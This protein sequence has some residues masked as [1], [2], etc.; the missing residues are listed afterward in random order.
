MAH[1]SAETKDYAS[2]EKNLISAE[3]SDGLRTDESNKQPSVYTE[4]LRSDTPRNVALPIEML[5]KLYLSPPTRDKV[6][7]RQTLP[8]PTPM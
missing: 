2:S 4:H 5:E 6:N 7:W 8:S 3:S 1:D